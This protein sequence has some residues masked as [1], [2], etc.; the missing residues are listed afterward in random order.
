MSDWADASRRAKDPYTS[1]AA[2]SRGSS[3]KRFLIFLSLPSV[4]FKLHSYAVVIEQNSLNIGRHRHRRRIGRHLR[5]QDGCGAAVPIANII[6]PREEVTILVDMV[7]SSYVVYGF[8]QHANC[9]VLEL[10]AREELPQ[11]RQLSKKPVF[12]TEE[13]ITLD[14]CKILS[15]KHPA[16][17]IR[18]DTIVRVDD[19]LVDSVLVHPEFVDEVT[20]SGA[21]PSRCGVGYPV[22]AKRGGGLLHVCTGTEDT[23]DSVEV[24]RTVKEAIESR[25]FSGN[26][27]NQFLHVHSMVAQGGKDLL[28]ERNPTANDVFGGRM[29]VDPELLLEY[30]FD[31]MRKRGVANVMQQCRRTCQ[32]PLRERYMAFSAVQERQLHDA[33]TVL[34]ARV[35][36]CPGSAVRPRDPAI[37]D[38]SEEMNFL[39]SLKR[40]SFH[41]LHQQRIVTGRRR[42]IGRPTEIVRLR[43]RRDVELR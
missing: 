4:N 23:L 15:K 25:G 35:S 9:F 41:Q 24:D 33:E 14:S 26:N 19:I 16:D 22:R 17:E 18:N 6:L 27:G 40:G 13:G 31:G 36:S 32:T 39:Q 29:V 38:R 43:V 10:R 5:L 20:I 12:S 8:V 30:G 42:E 1:T 3:S 34:V 2:P 37:V 21:C 28:A 11:T 7:A